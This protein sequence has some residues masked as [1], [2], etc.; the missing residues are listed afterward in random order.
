MH[1]RVGWQFFYF[2]A[3]LLLP[4]AHG[5]EGEDGERG[6]RAKALLGVNVWV[7]LRGLEATFSR[8]P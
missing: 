3:L 2:D 8:V 5:G 1:K 7:V 4:T 6:G